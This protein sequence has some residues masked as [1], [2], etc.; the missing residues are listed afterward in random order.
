MVL[1][2]LLSI[3]I[4]LPIFGAV[5]LLLLQKITG[6]DLWVKWAGLGLSLLILALCVPLYQNFDQTSAN[7]QFVE[8]HSWISILNIHYSLGVDGISVLFMILTAF[9]NVIIMLSSW[10]HIKTRVAE[11]MAI[12]LL[13]PIIFIRPQDARTTRLLCI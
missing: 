7:M 4:W 5:L 13:S 6:R 2:H 12:F 10:R 11:Y 1:Q 8:M 3:L 9:T